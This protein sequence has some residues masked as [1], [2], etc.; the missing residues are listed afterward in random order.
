MAPKA[1]FDVMQRMK[2]VG[3]NRFE[4]PC[5]GGHAEVLVRCR[6]EAGMEI[7]VNQGVTGPE[8]AVPLLTSGAGD[9]LMPDS[10]RRRRPCCRCRRW[11]AWPRVSASPA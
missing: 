10:A 9:Y 1:P 4:D 3:V 7:L 8:S 2:A 11:R 6:E 5:D